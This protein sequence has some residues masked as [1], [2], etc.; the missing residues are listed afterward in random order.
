M[1]HEEAKA[2]SLRSQLANGSSLGLFHR[3]PAYGRTSC[4]PA[5]QLPHV[6]GARGGVSSPVREG[7]TGREMGSLCSSSLTLMHDLE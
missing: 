3:D 2:P 4:H 6:G 7:T 5:L 1:E